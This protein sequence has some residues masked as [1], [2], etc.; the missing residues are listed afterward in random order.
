[1][2]GSRHPAYG[3]MHW[4]QGR[5]ESTSGTQCPASKG[6]SSH[7]RMN[8]LGAP[9]A[10][11]GAGA[12]EGCGGGGGAT[13]SEMACRSARNCCRSD[14]PR[15]ASP[16]ALATATHESA[17]SSIDCGSRLSTLGARGAGAVPA[18]L[19]PTCCSVAAPARRACAHVKHLIRA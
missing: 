6:G 4:Q 12:P 10:A 17:T 14:A 3:H 5:T 13:E 18:L 11:V 19:T 8:T 1:M 9:A 2:V 16:H 15:S 7:S